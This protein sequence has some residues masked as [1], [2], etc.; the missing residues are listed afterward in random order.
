M[1]NTPA[2]AELFAAVTACVARDT[3]F[4]ISGSSDPQVLVLAPHECPR[5]AAFT[6][7]DAMLD[8]ELDLWQDH[9]SVATALAT[10]AEAQ[11]HGLRVAFAQV[12]VPRA[13]VDVNR[14]LK[15][16][17]S[18][19]LLDRGAIDPRWGGDAQL[20]QAL[21]RLYLSGMEQIAALVALPS[22]RAVVSCHSYGQVG[23]TPDMAAGRTA[24]LRPMTA[25]VCGAPWQWADIAGLRQHLPRALH[26]VPWPAEFALLQELDRLGLVP[27]PDPYRV[28]KQWPWTIEAR[29][30]A[31][32]Y[33]A[34]AVAQ[35]L[36]PTAV[37]GWPWQGDPDAQP[38]VP[39]DQVAPLRAALCRYDD[40][41]LARRLH[42][43][44]DD[45]LVTGVELS[46][47]NLD[48]AQ[49]LGTALGAGVARWLQ[50]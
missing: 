47:G 33:L 5:D 8:G 11:R 29:A 1:P 3:L 44:A 30:R 36:A 45:K 41:E 9:G 21:S 10:V 37:L 13:V 24:E 50:G 25:F 28:V 18:G 26:Y 34:A 42:G 16:S 12:Q 23:S 19:E 20:V 32:Q 27:G 15:V 40:L 43:L 6:H 48:K 4:T 7:I 31:A 17:T 39:L 2:T 35:G 49:A 46:Q 38:P 14:E 22:V